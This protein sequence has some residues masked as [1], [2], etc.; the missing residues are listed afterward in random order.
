MFQKH[1]SRIVALFKATDFVF[2]ENFVTSNS[3]DDH[4]AIKLTG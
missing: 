3:L 2:K 4:T 1:C